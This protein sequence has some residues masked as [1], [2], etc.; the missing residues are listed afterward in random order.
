MQPTSSLSAT[1]PLP[2]GAVPV[3]ALTF[4]LH[5]QTDLNTVGSVRVSRRQPMAQLFDDTTK[6]SERRGEQRFDFRPSTMQGT[7]R[8]SPSLRASAAPTERAVTRVGGARRLW[9]LAATVLNSIKPLIPIVQA[10]PVRTTPSTRSVVRGSDRTGDC[11][12]RGSSMPSLLP[13][14]HTIAASRH[15]LV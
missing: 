15:R 3:P 10:A 2:R 13:H 11:Y 14:R 5:S 6:T 4:P 8:M 7:E 9:R 12:V 1:G